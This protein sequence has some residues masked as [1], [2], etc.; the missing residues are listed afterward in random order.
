[1]EYLSRHLTDPSSKKEFKH[2]PKCSKLK[3][4]HLS[5][6]D[7]LLLFS[8]GDPKAVGLLHD[9]F[10][11]FTK[12]SGLQAKMAKSG[13][14]FG[15]VDTSIRTIILQQLGY[16]QGDL[17]F[18]YL[19]IPLASKQL[20]LVQWQ[21]LIEKIV[22]KFSSWTAK[23]LSYAAKVLKTIEAYCR[24][25]IWSGA[26]VITKRALMSWERM[27]LQLAAGD[28]SSLIPNS[29]IRLPLLKSA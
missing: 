13:A 8:R 29:E 27:R 16:S 19:G 23:T 24:S 6:A 7:D 15:D 11:L 22:S 14:Y 5:C 10:V 20:S 21:P 3:I 2:H 1:M 4:T 28:S 9:R 17:P 26:N 18:R 25:Y 12:T